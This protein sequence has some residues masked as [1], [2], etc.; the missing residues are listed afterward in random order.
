MSSPLTPKAPPPRGKEAWRFRRVSRAQPHL[1]EEKPSLP[2]LWMAVGGVIL[3]VVI[4]GVFVVWRMTSS[5]PASVVL[6]TPATFSPTQ[7]VLPTKLPSTSTPVSV[8]TRTLVPATPTAT[9]MPTMTPT[10]PKPTA[11]PSAI[12]Y[13]V[14]PGDTLT[15]IAAQYHVTIRSIMVAN[16]LK[17]EII[18]AGQELIIPRPTPTPRP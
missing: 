4:V 2:I 17:N 6:P 13:R 15:E 3:I 10:V 16:N 11:T 7:T 1:D 5:T 18:Y 9:A 12:R 14:K 8:Q